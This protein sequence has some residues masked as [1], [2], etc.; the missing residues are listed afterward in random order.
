MMVLQRT[1][2]NKHTFSLHEISASYCQ[3][4]QCYFKGLGPGFAYLALLEI[5]TQAKLYENKRC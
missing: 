1:Q 5:K 3:A 2:L 4:Q